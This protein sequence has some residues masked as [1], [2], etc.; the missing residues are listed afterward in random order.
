[1]G[2]VTGFWANYIF[3]DVL[4]NIVNDNINDSDNVGVSSNVNGGDNNNSAVSFDHGMPA[5]SYILSLVVGC[6]I[7]LTIALILA[8]Q[9]FLFHFICFIL[10]LFLSFYFV[11][12]FLS[13]FILF[14]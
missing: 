12:L 10:L 7:P 4:M 11:L 5:M 8:F 14:F 2:I 3:V 6:V 1:L 9:V 13:C